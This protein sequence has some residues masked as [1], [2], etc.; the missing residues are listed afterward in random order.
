MTKNEDLE[1]HLT[2]DLATL[3][4]RLI[5]AEFCSDLYRAIAGNALSLA[6]DGQGARLSLSWKRAEDL[7]NELRRGVGREPMSLAQTGGEG[8]VDGTVAAELK[9]LG[10]KLRPR[11]TSQHDDAHL[12]SAPG[13][14]PADQGERRAPLD[15]DETNWEQRAH[16]EADAGERLYP[17]RP[18]ESGTR[19]GRDPE[20]RA[21][22]FR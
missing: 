11:V 7:V 5:D 14:P 3:G 2:N 15:P 20:E 21:R 17:G 18:G 9:R 22:P 8:E 10:W 12:G 1:R 16:E 6:S 4:D 13:P 19:R